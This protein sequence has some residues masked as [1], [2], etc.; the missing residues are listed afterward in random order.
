MITHLKDRYSDD[1]IRNYL[2]LMLDEIKW[3]SLRQICEAKN[4]YL[5]RFQTGGFQL[6]VQHI[7]RTRSV[8][9]KASEED[10]YSMLFSFWCKQ[11]KELVPV[12]DALL[13]TENIYGGKSTEEPTKNEELPKNN[14][15]KLTSCLED[16]DGLYILLFSRI[17]FSKEE[18]IVL[19]DSVGKKVDSGDNAVEEERKELIIAEKLRAEVKQLKGE[20]HAVAR[21]NKKLLREKGHLDEAIEKLC[22]ELESIK[23]TNR[24]NEE[25]IARLKS[26]EN[27]KIERLETEIERCRIKMKEM[28]EDLAG[29]GVEL[30]QKKS[31]LKRL[32]E[33]KDTI[34]KEFTRRIVDVLTKLNAP[35]IIKALNEP[36]EIKDY[37]LSVLSIPTVDEISPSGLRTIDIN[38]FWQKFIQH[39]NDT[40]KKLGEL[41]L[42]S[43]TEQYFIDRWPY[44]SDELVDVKYSLRARAVMIDFVYEILRKFYDPDKYIP[45]QSTVTQAISP[46]V[47]RKQGIFEEKLEELELDPKTIRSLKNVNINTIGDLVRKRDSD[48]LKIKNFGRKDLNQVI[49]ALSVKKLNLGMAVTNPK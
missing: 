49:E 34:E 18:E 17:T 25:E 22:D 23:N 42:Q 44:I 21:E 40:I 29:L 11:K 12:M 36:D 31:A 39:E 30:E 33:E 35:E 43:T 37:L 14:F 48:L 5:K 20:I 6:K 28:K 2:K 13:E 15:E 46:S 26:I 3:D 24:N 8:I 9:L 32:Q 27:E 47:T 45:S 16:R 4:K 1:E 7:D 19:V 10:D 38:N 41:T